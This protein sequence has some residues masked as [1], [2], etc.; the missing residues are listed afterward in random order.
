[1]FHRRMRS[2]LCRLVLLLAVA[3]WAKAL[4]QTMQPSFVG[5]ARDTAGVGQY[6]SRLAPVLRDSLQ[7]DRTNPTA[8]LMERWTT[9][10]EKARSEPAAFATALRRLQE[11]SAFFSAAV[12]G[13]DS[14]ALAASLA[15]VAQRAD[16]LSLQLRSLDSAQAAAVVR[17]SVGLRHAAEEFDRSSNAVSK[18]QVFAEGNIR[19]L[20]APP[21]NGDGKDVTT[22][23]TGLLGVTVQKA[24]TIWTASI[25][26]AS[27]VDTLRNAFGESLLLPGTGSTLVS[28]LL[29]VRGKERSLRFFTLPKNLGLYAYGSSS[30]SVWSRDVTDSIGTAL[31]DSSSATVI[32]LGGGAFYDVVQTRIGETQVGLTLEA[33]VAMRSV[34]G[35]ISAT[36]HDSLRASVIGNAGDRVFWGL[37]GGPQLTFGN[38]TG[39]LRLYFFP[40]KGVEGFSKAQVSAAFSVRASI[41]EGKF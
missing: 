24:T 3:P 27:T 21:E 17:A 7:L 4:G 36:K 30:K 20:A 32:G 41:L 26:V 11:D 28:G 25:S 6:V 13:G 5:E 19:G 22:A 14:L 1:M 10:E 38:V 18:V 33:G 2:G 29:A 40:H 16:L 8:A 39:A 9:A 23:A 35:D 15:R 31:T 34:G 12:R 37:E